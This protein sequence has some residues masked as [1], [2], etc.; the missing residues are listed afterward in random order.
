MIS[1]LLFFFS[2]FTTNHIEMH[3]FFPFDKNSFLFL[4]FFSQFDLTKWGR[5]YIINNA[6]AVAKKEP[7]FSLFYIIV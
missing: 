4:P 6:L 1:L 2:Y 5:T 7:S 3:A